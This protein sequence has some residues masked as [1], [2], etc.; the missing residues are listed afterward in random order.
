[1]PA[2]VG[3]LTVAVL[4]GAAVLVLHLRGSGGSPQNGHS[5]S[6]AGPSVSSSQPGSASSTP[7][8]PTTPRA[9]VNAYYRDLNLHHYLAAYRLNPSVHLNQT[10]SQFKAGYNT[11]QHDYVTITGI[12]GDVVSLNLTAQHTDGTLLYFSGTLTVRHGK[13]VVS[14]VH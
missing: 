5:S 10:Y 8:A 2:L 13:I 11:T 1:M 12:S 14:N 9:V 6:P 3:F 7:V 4:A